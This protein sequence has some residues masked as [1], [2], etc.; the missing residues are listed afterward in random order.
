MIEKILANSGASMQGKPRAA[1]YL[2]PLQ[3]LI[4]NT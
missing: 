1:G 4:A 2:C 3:M